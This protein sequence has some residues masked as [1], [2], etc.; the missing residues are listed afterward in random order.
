MQSRTMSKLPQRKT[1]LQGGITIIDTVIQSATEINVTSQRT[2]PIFHKEKGPSCFFLQG[3]SFFCN[4]KIYGTRSTVNI[5]RQLSKSKSILTAVADR[6]IVNVRVMPL[7][8]QLQHFLIV[9]RSI[10]RNTKQMLYIN[11]VQICFTNAYA[12]IQ[13]PHVLHKTLNTN[14]LGILFHLFTAK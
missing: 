9:L 5:N 3:Q 8:I 7:A 4:V 2:R 1:H 14:L 6:S 11:R 13:L 12:F 10:V